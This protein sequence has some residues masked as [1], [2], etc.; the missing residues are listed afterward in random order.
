M[1]HPSASEGG[2]ASVSNTL[3]HEDTG[4]PLIL[5]LG[6]TGTVAEVSVTGKLQLLR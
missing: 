3:M 4:L 1:A 6:L 5:L 2:G